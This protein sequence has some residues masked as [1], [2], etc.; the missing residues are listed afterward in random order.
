[1]DGDEDNIIACLVAEKLGARFTLAK[2]SRPDYIPIINSLSL[3]DRIVN[4]PL[5]MI[6]AILHFVR[7]QNVSAASLFH[8]LPGEL[9]EVQLKARHQWAGKAIR[10]LDVS[11]GL[12]IAAVR[13]GDDVVPATGDLVLA[14]NDLIV[15][16][17]LSDSVRKIEA[18]FRR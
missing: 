2:I 17:A 11:D 7:G 15:V 5:S 16:F 13:R 4:P 9:L 18:L 14:E 3:L 6:N 12:L 10:D 8:K 1:M